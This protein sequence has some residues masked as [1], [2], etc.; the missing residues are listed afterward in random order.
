MLSGLRTVNQV[1]FRCSRH[2][3]RSSSL[4]RCYSSQAARDAL[5]DAGFLATPEDSK[6]KKAKGNTGGKAS[7]TRR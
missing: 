2:V 6:D 7:K 3:L 1:R 5:T 4:T